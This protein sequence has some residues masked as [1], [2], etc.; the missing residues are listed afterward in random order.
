MGAKKIPLGIFYREDRPTY[1]DQIPVLKDRALVQN[2]VRVRDL[3]D[4]MKLYL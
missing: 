2:E 3:S 4:Y 1:E